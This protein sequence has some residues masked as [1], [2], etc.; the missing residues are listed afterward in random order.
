[1]HV[2]PYNLGGFATADHD[3]D[4]RPWWPN[5]NSELCK[6]HMPRIISLNFGH[7]DDKI[8]LGLISK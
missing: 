3:D 4:G 1:M 7:L 6:D 2:G 8:S 5:Y